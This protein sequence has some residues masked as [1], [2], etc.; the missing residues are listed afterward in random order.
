MT[1]ER[2]IDI[3]VLVLMWGAAFATMRWLMAGARL[4]AD[5]DAGIAR[6]AALLDEM[7]ACN[8]DMAEGSALLTYGAFDEAVEVFR[9]HCKVTVKEKRP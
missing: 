7:R 8:R 3:L 5:I 2:W 9:R 4:M 6:N 1:P